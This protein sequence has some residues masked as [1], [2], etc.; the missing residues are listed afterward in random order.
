MYKLVQKRKEVSMRE[1]ERP[2]TKTMNASEARQQWSSVIN[3]VY[4][5]QTRVLVEKSGIP[6]AGIVSAA[7]M[8]RLKRLDEEQA[9][10][11]A[12]LERVSQAF[13]DTPPEAVER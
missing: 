11:L 2:M 3:S 7:D 10:D 13:A 4:K 6:V 1:Q 5:G 12:A 8:E 9:A